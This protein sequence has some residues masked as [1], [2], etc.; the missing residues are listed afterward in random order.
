MPDRQELTAEL[1]EAK[2]PYWDAVL[3]HRVDQEAAPWG[4]ATC[5]AAM[6]DLEELK[7]IPLSD[8]AEIPQSNFPILK[9]ALTQ[10]RGQPTVLHAAKNYRADSFQGYIEDHHPD[11]HIERPV[12]LRFTMAHSQAAE[13]ER[14]SSWQWNEEL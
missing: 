10:V 13:I 8:L 12:T 2:Q 7:D 4:Y 1:K 6:R 3:A 14:L 11:Q 9:Q 5:F